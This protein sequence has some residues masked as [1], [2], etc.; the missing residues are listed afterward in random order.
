MRSNVA[1]GVKILRLRLRLRRVDV[2]LLGLLL[3]S[4]WSKGNFELMKLWASLV[5]RC[6][7][8]ARNFPS[9]ENYCSQKIGSRHPASANLFDAPAQ[10]RTSDAQS[11]ISSFS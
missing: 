11:F 5:H 4:G 7:G 6:A 1:A 2:C 10:R 9:M 8:D 3:G